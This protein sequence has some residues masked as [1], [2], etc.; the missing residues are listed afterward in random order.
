MKESY[1]FS[2][3]VGQRAV[4]LVHEHRIS[5]YSAVGDFGDELPIT[6]TSAYPGQLLF[7][8]SATLTAAC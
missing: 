3:V 1:R 8:G 7:R 4:H 2:A 6:V 5:M